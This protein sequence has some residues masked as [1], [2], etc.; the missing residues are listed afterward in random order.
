V[1]VYL[2]QPG[3]SGTLVQL[4]N[5]EVTATTKPDQ[6][7]F[8]FSP[9]QPGVYA[10]VVTVYDE[11]NNK[12]RAR[13]IFNYNDQPAFQ[14][15]HKP[16]YFIG[17]T[18]SSSFF[19]TDSDGKA[20]LSWAGRFLVNNEELGLS[21]SVEPWPIDEN[22][23][24]DVYGTTFGLRSISAI[25][26]SVGLNSITCKYRLDPTDAAAGGDQPEGGAEGPEGPVVRNCSIDQDAETATLDFDGMTVNNGD[27]VTVWLNASDYN[28][29]TVTVRAT[30]TQDSTM[31]VVGDHNFAANR[32][33]VDFS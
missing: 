30:A 3:T 14:D 20:V 2:L 19:T 23:I 9:R 7:N 5:P 26:G 33:D 22:T 10:I 1:E 12:A 27:G 15:T 18:N 16:V 28:G 24:D 29:N 21:R 6:N 17:P 8:H 13:K 11:A 25:T 31:P 4:A 32:D